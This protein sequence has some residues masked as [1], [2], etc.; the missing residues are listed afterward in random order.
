M[1]PWRTFLR[2]GFVVFTRFVLVP[3]LFLLAKAKQ[4]EQY[5]IFLVLAL[6]LFWH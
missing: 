5:N 2:F 6:L 4:L 3:F 1:K